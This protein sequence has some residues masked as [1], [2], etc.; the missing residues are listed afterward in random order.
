MTK[1]KNAQAKATPVRLRK[2]ALSLPGATE[3]SSCNKAAFK[4]GSKNFFFL[5]ERSGPEAGAFT[6]M[7]KLTAADS[8]EEAGKLSDSEPDNFSLGN[9]GWLSGYFSKGEGPPAKLFEAWI[10][11]SYRALAPKKLIAQL[12]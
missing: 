11:E 6:T 2:V 1:R 8:L 3:G 10:E 12:G 5:G 4:A 9:N 7:L